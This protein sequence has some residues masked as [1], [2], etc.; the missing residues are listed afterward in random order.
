MMAATGRASDTRNLVPLAP[1]LPRLDI[2][3]DCE[4]TSETSLDEEVRADRGKC[5][6]EN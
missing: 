2:V 5:E 3:E 1:P 6:C 4:E